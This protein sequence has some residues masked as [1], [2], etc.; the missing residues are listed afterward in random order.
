M[1]TFLNSLML[2][3][4][5][6]PSV[7]LSQDIV[8]GT[9]IDQANAMPVPGVN[10]I[11]KGTSTGATTDFDGKYTINAKAGDVLVFSYVGYKTSEV[12]YNGQSPL[13]VTLAEDAAQLDEVVLIGYGS[14]RKE[15]ATGSVDV[16]TSKDFNRGAIISTDQLLN[17]K[18][19]GVRI[20]TAGGSPDSAPNI[21]IRGGSS[22]NAQ[23]NPLIVIDGVPIGNDNPAGVANPLSLVNPNDIESF[24]I[25]KDASATAIYGSRASNGVI[26]ITTKKGTSGEVQY[27]FSSDISVSEAGEGLDMMTS[28]EYVRFIQEF[29]PDFVGNLGV[30]TGSVVTDQP[31]VQTIGGRTIY[32]TDWRDAVLRTSFTSNTN[33]SAR[34]NLFGNVPFRAS[35]GY[36]NAEG[37]VRTDDYERV[38]ASLK[39]SPSLLND[40]L[41]IDINA[42]GIYADK[43][44]I[45]ANGA[46]GSS[47]SYDPT[48][49][50]YNNAPDNRFGGYYTNT[51]VDGNRLILD[52]AFNPLAL[53]EQRTRPEQVNRFLGNIEFDYKMPFLPELKA[54]VNLGLDASRSKIEEI[55][56]DN[57]LVTYRFDNSNNDI[58]TNF[59]FNPGTNFRENQHITNT[60]FDAYTQYTKV[61]DNSVISKFDVQAGYSYQNFKNDGNQD[62]FEYDTETGLRIPTLNA[63]N[64]NNRYYNVLNLQSFFGRA[65]ID[66]AD[67][68]LFTF[69]MRAD[70][71]SL[72]TEENRWGYFP[73]VGMAWKLKE[74][75]FLKN[76]DFV[77]N[78]KVRLGWGK[79]GQQDITG[80]VGYY[81][82][83]PLFVA[84]SNSS[85]YLP[86]SSLYSALPFNPN[87]TWEKTSTYNLGL[88]FDFFKNSFITG[89]FDIYKRETTDL[90]ANV[91]VPPGQAFSNTFVDNVGETESEGFELGLNLNPIQNDNFSF[92]INSNISYNRAEVTNLDN[93]E[94]LQAGGTLRGTGAFL[95]YN[96]VGEQPNSAY[97]FKQVYDVDGN[98]IPNAFVDLNGDN[99]ITN[100]DR[101]FEQI[102]PNWTYGFGINMNYKNWDL[103][104]SFRGQIGGN[105][106]NF[107]KLNLGFTES[108]LPA[109]NN[110]IT[111]V[112]NFYDG[113]A[114]PAFS[115][116]IGN[117]QFSD[118]FLEDASFLRC[119]NISLGHR[120]DNMIKK[121]TVRLYAAV[122]NPFLITDYSGQDPENFGGIDGNFYPRPTVYTFG[123][124]LDF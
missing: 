124:N 49:P 63:D 103:S 21:R 45:D 72:F 121:G 93:I 41:K 54:V 27:N 89:S 67:K 112:L 26:I 111:N 78:L 2:L 86:G 69:T 99:R 120:F 6:V 37:I 46:L 56:S 5:L 40:H 77:N 22:L 10:I 19:A 119:D 87:L 90:L 64:P 100:E 39:F 97:V 50:L 95:L 81:P 11:I 115:N 3:V 75:A 110:S 83:I 80:T 14:V 114:N 8:T 15:D 82:S 70:G 66:I 58:N 106:Y 109:N 60:T 25:L 9:V 32:D 57:S 44:S 53:L 68:Y 61:L 91:P 71:S 23:N 13:D 17:G 101:Y 4:F 48:K 55:F 123:V 74:E 33:F 73:A 28:S 113:A 98:P 65:N 84:G 42:K 59:L 117:I 79:T 20:T 104:A 92:S 31:V 107:N 16:V 43:N 96:A 76:V 34:A 102:A 1:K 38:T 35:I 122:T 105:V 29:H 108:A 94:L 51:T 30:P 88:D 24:S 36:T 47:L 7:L 118:Y 116:V 85:Q 12:T 52:G 18:A 62:R